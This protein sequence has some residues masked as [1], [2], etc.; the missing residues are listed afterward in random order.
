MLEEKHRDGGFAAGGSLPVWVLIPAAALH[1]FALCD[2]NL[3]GAP[4]PDPSQ[5]VTVRFY[6]ELNDLLPEDLRRRSF[7]VPL[8][9][10]RSVKDVIESLNIPHTE[11]DL[12]LINGESAGFEA[13]LKPGDRVSVYPLFESLDIANV[14]HLRPR[15]LHE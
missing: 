4:M 5:S 7:A 13:V 8:R 6:E 3:W 15:P 12:I 1:S 2:E 14:Q 10:P 11:V 9:S